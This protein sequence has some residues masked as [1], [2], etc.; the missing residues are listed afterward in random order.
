VKVAKATRSGRKMAKS[1]AKIDM[2]QALLDPTSVFSNPQDVLKAD[3][4]DRETKIEILRRWGYDSLELEVAETEGMT[5]GEADLLDQ[6]LRALASLGAE[7]D[8]DHRPPTRQGD[9]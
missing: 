8:L 9:I 3:T 6:V 2:E 7:P 5:N 1:D 4:V